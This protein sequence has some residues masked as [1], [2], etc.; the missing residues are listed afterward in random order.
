MVYESDSVSNTRQMKLER[1]GKERIWVS[2]AQPSSKGL[3]RDFLVGNF[4]R[5]LNTS[6]YHYTKFI[7]IKTS[8]CSN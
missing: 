4:C 7:Y 5:S 6:D 1:E 8:R 2:I 3:R